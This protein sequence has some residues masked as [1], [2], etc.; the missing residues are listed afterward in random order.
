M[1]MRVWDTIQCDQGHSLAINT[2]VEQPRR[3][4]WSL[5]R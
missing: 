3:A 4:G 2:V 5:L 1:D